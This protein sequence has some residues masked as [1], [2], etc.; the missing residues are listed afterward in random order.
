MARWVKA[1]AAGELAPG[2]GKLVRVDGQDIALFN[3]NGTL[4][5]IGAICP[6]ESGPL[7]E[8]VVE[9]DTIVC[10]WHAFD[11]HAAT[12]ECSVD[13]GLRVPVFELK[14]EGGEVFIGI[15]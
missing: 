4:H 2:Q 15:P 5:A 9:G 14:V 11:F 1:A 3:I 7:H 12:G 8:G 6:H 13:P 10:P